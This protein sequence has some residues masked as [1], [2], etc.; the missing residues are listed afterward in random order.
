MSKF[1]MPAC[2][3]VATMALAG[4]GGSDSAAVAPVSGP[5]P[6]PTSTPI[7]HVVV[8][9]QENRTPDNLFHGLPGADIATNGINSSGQTIPLAKGNMVTTYDLGHRHVDFVAMY[10]G[11]KMDGADKVSASCMT[12]PS[13]C[14][15]NVQFQYV[16]PAQVLAYFQL[17]QRFTFGDR[18][19]QTN[20]GPSF[21][22]HQYIISGTSAPSVGGQY[23]GWFV[24]ENPTPNAKPTG[25]AEAPPDGL[26]TLIDPNGVESASIFPCFEHPTVIDLLDQAGIS[27][28]YYAPSTGSIWTGPNAIRHLR[29]GAD[30]A[31]VVVPQTSV[32]TDIASN[33]LAQVSWVIPNGEAS[34]HALS[35]DG[36]GPSWVAAVT[37][38]LGNSPY[39]SDT[40]IVIAWDDWGG[41][42]DH[43]AP[44]VRNA[45]ELGF[46]VPL[47][48]VSPYAKSGYVSHVQHDFGSIVHF[49]ETT[50]SLGT[51]GYADTSADDLSDCF[52][53]VQS[54]ISWVNVAATLGPAHFLAQAKSPQSDPDD[55]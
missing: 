6:P 48:V 35:T 2:L 53:F 52:N 9:F 10:D 19:F 26:V 1:L 55:D 20:Q 50:F 29:E 45:Y 14:P 46:R 17:A 36:S 25:C 3:I 47:I 24:A 5:P 15:A 22:A 40:A 8:I 42:Y 7:K 51:L 33:R 43:V 38:A 49:I 4:C 11:G 27:W 39:W 30:W 31:N 21:P 44:T 37:N 28:R 32:L 34:D 12:E 16:D 13:G 18:M 23:A 41:W 54:P